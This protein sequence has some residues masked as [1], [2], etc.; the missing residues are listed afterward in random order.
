MTHLFQIIYY[1]M[2]WNIIKCVYINKKPGKT[3]WSLYDF[4]SINLAHIKGLLC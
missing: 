4:N 3:P 2:K 1:T